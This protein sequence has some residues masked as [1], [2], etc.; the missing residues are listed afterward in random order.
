MKDKEKSELTKM[1]SYRAKPSI[2]EK[3][4]KW[5][6][7]HNTSVSAELNKHMESCVSK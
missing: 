1:V 2:V 4:K 3:F 7:K 6:K 5:C